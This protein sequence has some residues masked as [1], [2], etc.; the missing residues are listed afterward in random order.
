VAAPP[1]LGGIKYFIIQ[2]VKEI[3]ERSSQPACFELLLDVL[4]CKEESKMFTPRRC[5]HFG[6]N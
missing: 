1:A 5:A 6:G 4:K 3:W 2:G